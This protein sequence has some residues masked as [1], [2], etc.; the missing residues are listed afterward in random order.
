MPRCRSRLWVGAASV[1]E[2]DS[3]QNALEAFKVRTWGGSLGGLHA[4]S[5]GGQ[6][7]ERAG[8]LLGADVG[9]VPWI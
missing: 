4:G 8:G 2:V 7:A 3:L 9:R 6:P 1:G 5:H